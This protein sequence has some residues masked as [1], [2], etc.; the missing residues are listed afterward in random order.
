MERQTPDGILS[1]NIGKLLREGEDENQYREIPV[2]KPGLVQFHRGLGGLINGG[3]GGG[4][5][6][7]FAK[8]YRGGCMKLP[9]NCKI[10]ADEVHKGGLISAGAYNRCNFFVVHI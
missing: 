10:P 7:R 6:N 9:R 3:V 8:P 5:G 1:S 4:G 2:I